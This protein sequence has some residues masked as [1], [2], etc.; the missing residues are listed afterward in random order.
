MLSTTSLERLAALAPLR[1]HWLDDVTVTGRWSEDRVS[2]GLPAVS[3][4]GRAAE[5]GSGDSA[6]SG[7]F[8]TGRPCGRTLCV[9]YANA[10][11]LSRLIKAAAARRVQDWTNTAREL[12]LDG[13]ERNL[14]SGSDW[15]LDYRRWSFCKKRCWKMKRAIFFIISSLAEFRTHNNCSYYKRRWFWLMVVIANG[16]GRGKKVKQFKL[17]IQVNVIVK[18]VVWG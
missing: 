13:V 11:R 12:V 1:Q 10:R 8:F 18:K 2:R 7:R 15:C 6:L 9:L 4:I 3:Q 14:L 17:V 16:N 5:C